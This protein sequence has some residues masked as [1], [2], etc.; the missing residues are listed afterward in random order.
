[1]GFERRAPCA[2]SFMTPSPPRVLCPERSVQA[3]P[4]VTPAR[5]CLRLR[6]ANATARCRRRNSMLPESAEPA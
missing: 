4:S 2:R 1:M 6:A 3:I 5:S